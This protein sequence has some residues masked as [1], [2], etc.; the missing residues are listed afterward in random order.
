[1]A[2]KRLSK[3]ARE[4]NVGISTIVDFLGSHGVEISTNPNTKIEPAVY[5]QLLGEFQKSK[6]VKDKVNEVRTEKEEQK[7]LVAK[8]R[9][10]E[11]EAKDEAIEVA[12]EE[13]LKQTLEAEKAEEP[14]E[15]KSGLKV[16]GKIDLPGTKPKSP[17][18]KTEEIKK[19]AEEKEP[20][21]P[22]VPETIKV[23]TNKLKAP[24]VLGK[25][26]LPKKPTKK[27]NT[28]GADQS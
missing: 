24:A 13:A 1:M 19:V 21:A 12:K 2:V 4:L 26:E 25:I 22:K 17:P 5:E 8:Q 11:K 10:A 9:Q 18:V 6:S 15:K 23:D 28:L 27:N 3:V 7:E 16:L 14:E 20:E